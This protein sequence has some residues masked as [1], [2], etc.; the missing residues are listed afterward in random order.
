MTELDGVFPDLALELIN[1]FGKEIEYRSVAIGA[2][3]VA[4]ATNATAEVKANIKALV[5]DYSLQ[6]SG[7]GFASGL[8]ES[9]DKKLTIAAMALP[10][11]PTPS[12]TFKLNA[13]DENDYT[14]IN[15]KA[16]YSGEMV[17]VYEIQG[18]L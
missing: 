1:E 6:N 8:I 7:Q 18:R 3:D 16:V 9:G 4:T 10:S 13:T 12:D 14:I 2:Y 11:E 15:I 17:A 5:E